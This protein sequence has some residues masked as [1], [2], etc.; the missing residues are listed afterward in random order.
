[1]SEHP[2]VA[3]IV[4]GYEAFAARDINGVLGLLSEDIVW[5]VSGGCFAGD[6]KGRDEV[7]AHFH[8][9]AAFTGGTLLLNVLEVFA[10]D[11]HAVAHVRET[12]TRAADGARL[13]V[14]EA[15]VFHLNGNGRAV[16]WWHIHS[17]P[18]AYEA[19]FA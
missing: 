10:D 13:D 1:M 7:T 19:F 2:N 3:R 9:L 14:R 5:H 8:E 15:H 11:H 16:E 18:D 6:R 17:D 4:R 12:A